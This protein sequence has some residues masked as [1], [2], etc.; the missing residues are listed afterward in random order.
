MDS[1]RPPRQPMAEHVRGMVPRTSMPFEYIGPD[2]ARVLRPRTHAGRKRPTGHLARPLDDGRLLDTMRNFSLSDRTHRQAAERRPDAGPWQERHGGCGESPNMTTTLLHAQ[3]GSPRC[4]WNRG[5]HFYVSTWTEIVL[6]LGDRMSK[7][8]DSVHLC[9]RGACVT[10]TVNGLTRSSQ[11]VTLGGGAKPGFADSNKFQAC[12]FLRRLSLS[13]SS[14]ALVSSVTM[15]GRTSARRGQ[16]PRPRTSGSDI[17]VRSRT[18]A[19][20]PRGGCGSNPD[21]ILMSVAAVFGPGAYVRPPMVTRD[22]SADEDLESESRRRKR[23][24]WNLFEIGEPW[25]CTATERHALGAPGQAIYRRRHTRAAH[26]K[27]NAIPNFRHPIAK[28]QH[29]F[30]PCLR[31]EMTS[32]IPETTR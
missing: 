7:S 10:A 3:T 31:L 26:A 5:C 23:H 29:D 27:V 13:R 9:V 17:R 22:T 4:F 12:L 24:A 30:S 32:S 20:P 19:A 14:S 1:V 18:A 6:L 25:L 8:G 21:G 15:G 16:R 2:P 28:K 11:R